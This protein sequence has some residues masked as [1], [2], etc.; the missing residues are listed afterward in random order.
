MAGWT[1]DP[2]ERIIA[3]DPIV[4]IDHVDEFGAPWFKRELIADDG[5]MEYHSLTITDNDSWELVTEQD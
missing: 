2:L 4:T 3:S 1:A 5:T